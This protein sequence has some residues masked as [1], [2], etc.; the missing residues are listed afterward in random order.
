[1]QNSPRFAACVAFLVAA[2]AY[3]Q[4]WVG[5]ASGNVSTAANWTPAVTPVNDGSATLTFPT[6][7]ASSVNFDSTYS[8]TGMV[9]TGTSSYSLNGSALT[10]G[11][12]G[13]ADSASAAQF[14]NNAIT[15][16][17]GATF[18]TTA[19]TVGSNLTFTS[20]INIGANTLTLNTAGG[21]LSVLAN[22]T[23]TG[24]V[25]ATGSGV[26]FLSG[27]TNT[28][29]GGTTISSGGTLQFGDISGTGVSIPGNVTD[30]GTLNIKA[31]TASY[32]YNNVISGS[33]K[34]QFLGTNTVTLN[35]ANTYSGTTLIASG[36]VVVGTTNALP[37]G[38]ALS[39]GAGAILDVAANQTLTQFGGTN[40]TSTIK[41]EG[42]NSLTIALGALTSGTLFSGNITDGTVAGGQLIIGASTSSPQH[43]V[44]LLGT[45]TYTGGT[46]IQSGGVL[47]LGNNSTTGS[48]TGNV[49]N[50]GQL[51]FHRS[52]SVTFNGVISGSGSV[53]Q[54]VSSGTTNGK[55]TLT[56]ANTY[57]G[58]TLVSGGTLLIANSSGS[59]TGTGAVTV[60][61]AIA[62][63][64]ATFGGTGS[65]TG[66]LT[67]NTWGTVFTEGALGVGPTTLN[68]GSRIAWKL[69]DA[70]GAAGTGY[71][72][73]NVNGAL[74][75]NALAT[76]GNFLT[77]APFTFNGSSTGLAA[78][79]DTTQ[80]YS[81]VLASSTG[82]SGFD[83]NAVTL[84]LTGFQ[85]QYT[86]TWAVTTSG[87]NLLLNYTGGAAIP[88]P[89]TSALV[90]GLAA[91]ALALRRRKARRAT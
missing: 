14:I 24:S 89:A 6:A 80:S 26:I 30:N 88:E 20:A 35:A 36:T 2:S 74:T 42:G 19:G 67:V 38:S 9:F 29:S 87:N 66:A 78:S 25:S 13:V 73:L 34:V 47:R 12:G 91:C 8:L 62:S 33:G 45:N 85:N 16:G 53:S 83:A 3:G 86:G 61:P 79:F 90:V 59:A 76:S 27:A 4:T 41:I 28:W 31:S 68:A 71:G 84:D 10:L 70:S 63:F 17:A 81:F 37:T 32:T 58:G 56:A 44:T 18:A 65:I 48:I 23:G 72:T 40:A 60:T 82:I 55:T 77:I 51:I 1:M 43:T 52:D 75:L 54:G 57:S 7:T 22:I 15:L 64:S 46:T 49:A 69:N 11:S 5:G 50:D 39:M 21:A